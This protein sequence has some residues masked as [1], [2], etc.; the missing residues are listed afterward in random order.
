MGKTYKKEKGYGGFF[1]EVSDYF[2]GKHKT[3]KDKSKRRKEAP[4]S[5]YETDEDHVFIEKMRKRK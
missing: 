5:E 4:L 1:D 3:S 2:Y